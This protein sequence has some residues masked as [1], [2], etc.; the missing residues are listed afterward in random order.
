MSAPSIVSRSKTTGKVLA[1]ALV[2]ALALSA[3][4]TPQQNEVAR[5]VNNSRAAYGRAPLGQNGELSDKAQRW[6][7]YLAGS[8][9]LAHSDL[10]SGIS[11]RW[12]SLAEN[13]GSGSSIGSVHQQ[14]MNSS[15]HRANILNGRF[16][17]IGTGYATGGG[18][19]Y[20][21]QVFMQY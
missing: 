12:R 14:Y 18:G 11:Y 15:G 5:H 1:F 20:T 16:N 10:P 17:Y 3:C 7:E 4:L 6:A 8:G 19:V 9:G 2:L 21:V 13:V